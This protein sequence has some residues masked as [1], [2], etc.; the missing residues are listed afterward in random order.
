MKE[1]PFIRGPRPERPLRP[2]YLK[3]GRS[4]L[5]SL[6]G[7]ALVTGVGIVSFAVGYPSGSGSPVAS[8]GAGLAAKSGSAAA[9]EEL[10]TASDRTRPDFLAKLST[11]PPTPVAQ[12]P[13][14]S[15]LA[16][17]A[18]AEKIEAAASVT[19]SI[20]EAKKSPRTISMAQPSAT[21]AKPL[22]ALPP[23]Q[24]L[25]AA[26]ATAPKPAT[27]KPSSPPARKPAAQEHA[28][29]T[30]STTLAGFFRRPGLSKPLPPPDPAR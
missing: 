21:A 11:A 9:G 22:A 30:S 24:N 13:T 7:L 27:V 5:R 4:L 19:G 3:T 14:A 12:E 20:V 8:H 17:A 1:H 18:L 2:A 29:A 6:A 26:A 16:S 15:G 28:A 10:R 23:R 25:A